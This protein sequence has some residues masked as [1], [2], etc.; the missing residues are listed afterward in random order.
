MITFSVLNHCKASADN[1]TKRFFQS[2]FSRLSTQQLMLGSILWA[3]AT[4]LHSS[5]RVTGNFLP[6]HSGA[7]FR[8]TAV[9]FLLQSA[10]QLEGNQA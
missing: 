2:F 1:T 3:Q 10:Q 9:T 6:G 8:T 5:T 7:Y 4:F